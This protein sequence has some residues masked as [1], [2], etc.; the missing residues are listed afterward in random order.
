MSNTL[1]IRRGFTYYAEVPVRVAIGTGAGSPL[2]MTGGTIT[3]IVY[4]T[5]AGSTFSCGLKTGT[6][7]TVKLE[8]LPTETSSL[9]TGSHRCLL[10]VSLPSGEKYALTSRDDRAV[11]T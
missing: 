3:F 11:V 7:D 9:V 5:T 6:T 10:E 8:L 1:N 4:D 2:N